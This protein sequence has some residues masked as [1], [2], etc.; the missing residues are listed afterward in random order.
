MKTF[1]IFI[2][3]LLFARHSYTQNC[4]QD[5]FLIQVNNYKTGEFCFVNKARDTI[6]PFGKYE[7]CTDDTLKCY[8]IVYS[9]S[10]GVFYALNN[11]GKVMYQVYAYDSGPD[12]PS[13]DLFR[14]I[15]NNKIGYAHGSTGEI[16]ITPKY[17]CATSFL[18]GMAMVSNNCKQKRPGK[19]VHQKEKDWIC[20]DTNGNPINQ[21]KDIDFE[22]FIGDY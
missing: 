18:N 8:A 21:P 3:T 19:H 15:I 6:V 9:Y 5:S 22:D 12:V 13:N 20:I 4:N 17:K 1:L 14:I 2:L 7:Q 16:I 10:P 11:Q